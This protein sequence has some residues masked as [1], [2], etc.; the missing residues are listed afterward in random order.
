MYV[1]C[2]ALV[3]DDGAENSPG[4]AWICECINRARNPDFMVAVDIVASGTDQPTVNEII[5][6]IEQWLNTLDYEPLSVLFDATADV[7]DQIFE[8][9]E[10][11]RGRDGR[12]IALCPSNTAPATHA[13]GL[14]H[15]ICASAVEA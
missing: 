3:A 6:P 14:L 9:N 2:A 5:K 8:F 13:Y 11:S 7:T 15:A 4:Q 12:V 10:D 1:E